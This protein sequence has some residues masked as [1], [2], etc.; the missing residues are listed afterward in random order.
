MA[1][2]FP[3]SANAW[4][5]ASIAGL[6]GLVASVGILAYWINVGGYVTRQNLIRHQEVP[7][8]HRHHVQSMGIDCRY[9]HWS[10]E[11]SN[12]A[13]IPPTH[14]CMTCHSQI[15]VDS[16]M[17]A[18]VRE[19]YDENTALVWNKVHDLPDY[20]YFNH[21]IHVKKGIGCAS[22]HGPVQQMALVWQE[23]TL[24]MS[25][26][27]ECHR[28]PEQFIR[29]TSEIY[30]MTWDPSPAQQEELGRHLVESYNVQSQDHCY[31]CHR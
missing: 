27:L 24:H 31:T 26:C 19:S 16:P 23:N 15:W 12:Y 1:Q 13:G 10:A 25:W 6:I 4:V 29:P 2:I 9:C 18:P 14:T 5:R 11:E 7:F 21:S 20:V 3:P 17:L 28:N 22:C 8:S 30:N